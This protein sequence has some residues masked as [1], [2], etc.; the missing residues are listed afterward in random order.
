MRRV[1][2]GLLF[3]VVVIAGAC[4]DRDDGS[5][6]ATSEHWVTTTSVPDTASTSET[7]GVG[8]ATPTVEA[9]S[10]TTSAP[11]MVRMLAVDDLA[12]DSGAPVRLR[13]RSRRR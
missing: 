5:Q 3:S 11:E 4:G 12:F 6:D 9:E 7:S 10:S 1:W 2:L 13:H 8:L